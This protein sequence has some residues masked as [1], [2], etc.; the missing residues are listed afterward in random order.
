M[1]QTMECQLW[2]DPLVSIF[3]HQNMFYVYKSYDFWF[4]FLIEK[5]RQAKSVS[6]VW[7]EQESSDEV[8]SDTE[9]LGMLNIISFYIKKKCIYLSCICF[10]R[11]YG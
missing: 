5:S 3:I 6:K 4:L 11:F 7:S 8:D 1:V 9:G 10:N 2:Q